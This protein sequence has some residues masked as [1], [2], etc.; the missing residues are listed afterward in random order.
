MS[1]LKEKTVEVLITK[2]V[3]VLS[4]ITKPIKKT[5]GHT[6]PFKLGEIGGDKVR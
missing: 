6:P 2:T 4:E 3:D 1:D 5:L